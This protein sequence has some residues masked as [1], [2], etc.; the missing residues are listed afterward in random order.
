MPEASISGEERRNKERGTDWKEG[1]IEDHYQSQS[2]MGLR[3]TQSLVQ[4]P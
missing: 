1:L 4:M 2:T 3:T